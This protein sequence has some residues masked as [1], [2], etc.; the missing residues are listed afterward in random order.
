MGILW[1]YFD[2]TAHL[3]KHLYHRI[4]TRTGVRGPLG[5]VNMFLLTQKKGQTGHKLSLLGSHP[6][7]FILQNSNMSTLAPPF[8]EIPLAVLVV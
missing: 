6:S 5:D 4:T 2:P 1:G 7:L 8:F 3:G